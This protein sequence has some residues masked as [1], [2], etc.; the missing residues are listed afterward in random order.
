M[1][2]NLLLFLFCSIVFFACRVTDQPDQHTDIDL[3]LK[4]LKVEGR[5]I[6]NGI[7]GKDSYDYGKVKK[8]SILVEA[9]TNGSD[10]M[11]TVGTE[12]FQSTD[13]APYLLVT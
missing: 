9:K 2:R 7:D 1:R 12:Y 10:V 3:S 4:E 8:Y 6:L 11:V 5:S 13:T